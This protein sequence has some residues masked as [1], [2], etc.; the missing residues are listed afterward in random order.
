MTSAPTLTL[1]AQFII[2]VRVTYLLLAAIALFM[3]IPSIVRVATQRFVIGDWPL[4]LVGGFAAGGLVFQLRT[5]I[6]GTGDFSS[7]WTFVSLCILISTVGVFLMVRKR[8]QYFAQKA[9]RWLPY[10]DHIDALVDFCILDTVEGTGEAQFFSDMMRER[11]I[12]ILAK[13]RAQGK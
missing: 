5:F 1:L 12:S 9:R 11:A 6:T 13:R 3:C 7:I 4:V 10:E 2:G 8:L